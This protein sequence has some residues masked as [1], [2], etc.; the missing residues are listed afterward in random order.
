MQK[1]AG[2]PPPPRI[3]KRRHCGY[4]KKT[5]FVPCQNEREAR[6]CRSGQ[7]A[8]AEAYRISNTMFHPKR[9]QYTLAIARFHQHHDQ[10]LL[11]QEL[12]D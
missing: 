4:C 2:N 12:E 6:F 10:Y 7:R 8:L 3:R 9:L 11:M 5:K 1:A